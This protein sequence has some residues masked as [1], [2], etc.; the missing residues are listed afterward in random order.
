MSS[1]HYSQILLKNCIIWLDK[2]IKMT[3]NDD[4]IF[5]D[6]KMTDVDGRLCTVLQHLIS[7]SNFKP[8]TRTN[9]YTGQRN[10]GST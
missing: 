3:T 1:M 4:E 5:R 9:V 8:L 2:L 6:C 10:A 7:F